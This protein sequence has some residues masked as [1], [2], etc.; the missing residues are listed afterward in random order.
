MSQRLVKLAASLQQKKIR[1]KEQLFIAEGEKL[2]IDLLST[3]KAKH[4]LCSEEWAEIHTE[5]HTTVVTQA[6]LKKASAL[7]HHSPVIGVFEIPKPKPFKVEELPALALDTLQDPG[8][9]GTIIRTAAWFGFKH[10]ICSPDTVD[11]YNPK[12]VQ[13]TMGA[14]SMVQIH[15]IPLPSFFEELKAEN[16]AIYGT[17]LEGE[18]IYKT[19]FKRKSIIVIGNEGQGI[20]K[21]LK[22]YINTPIHI[23]AF[24][25]NA[26]ESLNASVSAAIVCSEMARTTQS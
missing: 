23:P 10:I 21:E 16:I 6:A 4:I 24:T 7:K 12:V 5:L 1:T 14:L 9:F 13:A 8:N 15:Y 19:Q 20:S 2:V 11:I 22:S 25:N 18:N 17:Y 3:F 26:P